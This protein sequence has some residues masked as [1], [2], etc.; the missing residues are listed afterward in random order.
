MAVERIRP[1]VELIELRKKLDRMTERIISL[2]VDRV[3][4][5]VNEVIYLPD[6]LAIEGAPDVSLFRFALEGLEAYHTSLGRYNY[7][8]QFP[9]LN[10]T[11]SGPQV[12]REVAQIPLSP[13]NIDIKDSLFAFYKNLVSKYCKPGDDPNTYG[14]SAYLDA[15]LVELIHERVNLGR[16]VSEAKIDR[17]PSISLLGSPELL[18]PKLKDRD[19]EEALVARARQLAESNGLDPKMAEE[20][21]RWMVET[22]LFIEIAYIQQM[23][24][25]TQAILNEV[26]IV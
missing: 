22:T 25:P 8:D 26:T 14:A 19:R 15:Q 5:P 10:I 17:D 3:S 1:Q 2:F 11:P 9:L 23:D 20:S 21:F 16:F 13:A 4:L 24:T 18:M 12:R 6:G 7:P